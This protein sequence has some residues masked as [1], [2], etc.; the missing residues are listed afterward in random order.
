[1]WANKNVVRVH[2][3]ISEDAARFLGAQVTDKRPMYRI[4][5]DIIE[6]HVSG[7][8]PYP[9]KSKTL[10]A[11]QSV[12]R[13][14]GYCD[15]EALIQDLASSF[16]RVYRWHNSQ[17]DDYE[18]DVLNKDIDDMFS[19]MIVVTKSHE[20]ELRVKKRKI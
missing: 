16:L 8:Q 19:E 17:H 11:L 13:E 12:V 18:E 2:T 4:I 14:T 3:R 6:A 15:V 10:E 9:L 7:V 20:K 5:R 1:M